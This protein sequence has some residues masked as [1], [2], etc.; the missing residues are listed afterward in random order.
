MVRIGE[1]TASLNKLD[2]T[3]GEPTVWKGMD[4]PVN[5]LPQF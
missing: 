4:P 3:V 1:Y 2:M 5:F